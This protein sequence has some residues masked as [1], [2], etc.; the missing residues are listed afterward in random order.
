[1]MTREELYAMHTD[2]H[3]ET[4]ILK[5]ELEKKAHYSGYNMDIETHPDEVV[6]VGPKHQ[7]PTKN[8]AYRR[9]LAAVTRQQQKINRKR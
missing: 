4:N 8:R 3:E 6:I 7:S 5:Q 2:K 9:K 1:M